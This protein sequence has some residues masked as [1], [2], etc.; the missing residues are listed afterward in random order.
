MELLLY[1]ENRLHL[2]EESDVVLLR[3]EE[4]GS[5]APPGVD[6]DNRLTTLFDALSM[7]GNLSSLS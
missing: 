4:P 6:I 3:P 5:L 2:I 7:V 1:R